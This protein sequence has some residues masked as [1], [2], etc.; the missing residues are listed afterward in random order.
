[1]VKL[2]KKIGKLLSEYII[3]KDGQ[4]IASLKK[5]F[6]IVSPEVSGTIFYEELNI[7]GDILGY[8]YDIILGERTIA[9]VDSDSS[10]WVADTYVY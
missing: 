6:R 5:K 9:H 7:R 8:D 10:K 3:E 2:K 1:M 4:E